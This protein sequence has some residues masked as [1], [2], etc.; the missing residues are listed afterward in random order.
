MK[1]VIDGKRT[2]VSYRIDHREMQPRSPFKVSVLRTT[3]VAQ[4]K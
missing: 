4:T 2:N 1:Y 3:P